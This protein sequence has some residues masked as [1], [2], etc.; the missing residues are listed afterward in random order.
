MSNTFITPNM[1]LIVPAVDVDPGPD[2]ANS[3]NASLTILDQH[4]HVPG[5][6]VLITPAAININTDLTFSSNN[7]IGLRSSRYTIQSSALSGASDIACFYSSGVDGDAFYNDG[8]GNQIRITQSG[9]VAGSAGTITG[10]PS[11]TASASYQSASGTFQFQQ[12]TAT[13]A[14]IDVASVIIRY[15]GSYPTPSGNAIVIEAPTSLSSLYSLTLPALPPQL[16]VMTLA[17]DG[18]ISSTTWDQVGVNMTTVGADAIINTATGNRNVVVS[19][20]NAAANLSIIRGLIASGGAITSGEG[21][22]VSNPGSGT[23]I[24][25]FTIPFADIPAVICTSANGPSNLVMVTQPLVGSVDIFT[26]VGSTGAANNAGF[27]F[28]AIG[29]V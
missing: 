26:N 4:S 23:Y 14:N 1:S 12:A 29:Q 19:N 2:W 3:I 22:T 7:A 18:T 9:S 17:T 13:G 11:G 10:L 25:T 20:T 21:F 24:I 27:S 28:I 8:L 16:N 15:P 5:S 6:G